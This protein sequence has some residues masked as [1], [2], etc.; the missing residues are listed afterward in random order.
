M[1]K[2]VMPQKTEETWQKLGIQLSSQQAYLKDLD[3]WGGLKPGLQV[4][5]KG[6][7]FPRIET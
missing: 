3:E 7:L 5:P 4:I 6:M 1:L 2:P